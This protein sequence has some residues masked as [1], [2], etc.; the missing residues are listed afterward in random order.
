MFTLTVGWI[1]PEEKLLIPNAS[2]ADAVNGLPRTGTGAILE[3]DIL[4]GSL[5]GIEGGGRILAGGV[6]DTAGAVAGELILNGV[7]A[8][9][10]GLNSSDSELSLFCSSA[11]GSKSS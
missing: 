7:A 1:D 5:A 11:R 4:F 8:E 9:P 3:P 2:F 6:E 10:R